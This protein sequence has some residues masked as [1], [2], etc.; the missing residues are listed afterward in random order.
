MKGAIGTTIT[1][2][3]ATIIVFFIS[4]AFLAIVGVTFAKNSLPFIGEKNEANFEGADFGDS[5]DGRMLENILK[6]E[7]ELNGEKT[8]FEEAFAE[9]YGDDEKLYEMIDKN[10][11]ECI[12]YYFR[13]P[14]G[15][16]YRYDEF[17][18]EFGEGITN[19]VINDL[20]NVKYQIVEGDEKIEIEFGGKFKC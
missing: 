3:A 20:G 16:A 8:S 2:A 7:V 4:L 19:G 11:D 13:I 15:Y 9:L 18:G 5:Q 1:W 10:I 12:D 17:K 6:S 14:S